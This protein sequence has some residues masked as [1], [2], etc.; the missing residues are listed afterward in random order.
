MC[1][2]SVS[3]DALVKVKTAL[4]EYHIDISG[5]STRLEQHTT[6]ILKSAE[7]EMQKIKR[8]IEETV[9]RIN[10]LKTR[11]KQLDD[12]ISQMTNE[13]RSAE[14]NIET[15]QNQIVIKQNKADHIKQNIA[16]LEK[17]VS[18]TTDTDAITEIQEAIS[19][20]LRQLSQ[21]ESEIN[22]LRNQI[23]ELQ[24]R[25]LQLKRTIKEAKYDKAKCE[26]E[27]LATER[28][29]DRLENKQ[30]RMKTALD[31]LNDNIE[32]I[33]AASKSFET[34]ATS[35]AEQSVGNIDKCIAAIDEY[36]G[37]SQGG[38]SGDSQGCFGRR[39]ASAAQIPLAIAGAYVP[40]N[41]YIQEIMNQPI[42]GHHQA[43][44]RTEDE[45]SRMICE[46]MGSAPES[47]V[48]EYP[49]QEY[50]EYRDPPK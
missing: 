15:M 41:E 28:L 9:E 10:Q 47:I 37:V 50:G 38:S 35:K 12:A 30:E 34:R 36:L 14:L 21:I 43:Y 4:K 25:I 46:G 22:H 2:V 7:L 23:M 29:L 32:T 13:M 33:L 1:E 27:L 45:R 31:R 44:E 42:I 49:E 16:V 17:M 48:I 8:Q 6:E 20:L 40:P 19:K 3:K 18:N 5:F 24:E 26:D 39:I 11:I